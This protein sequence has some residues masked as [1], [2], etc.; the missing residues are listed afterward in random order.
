VRLVLMAMTT[1]GS[2]PLDR[3]SF[4]SDDTILV[5]RETTGG[6]SHM[7]ECAVSGFAFPLRT[8]TRSL[9]VTQAGRPRCTKRSV[10]P[11]D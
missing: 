7:H 4:V 3:F 1:S 2:I 5:S 9:N 11:A 8:E 10:R 6:P